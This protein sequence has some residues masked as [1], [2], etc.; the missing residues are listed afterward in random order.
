MALS[1]SAYALWAL[2]LGG[3]VVLFARQKGRKYPPGPKPLPIVGNLFDQPKLEPWKVYQEW[4]RQYD[5]DIIYFRLLSTHVIVLNSIQVAK[6]LLEKRALVYSGRPFSVM[7]HELTGWDRNLALMDYG[8]EWRSHRRMFHQQF[9]PKV[10]PEYHPASQRGISRFLNLLHESPDNFPRHIRFMTGAMILRLMYGVEAQP[11]DDRNI[12]LS[13]KAVDVLSDMANAGAYL[14]DMVP[15]LKYLP[16]WFPGAVFKRQASEWKPIVDEMFFR[17]F[18]ELKAAVDNGHPRPC[19]ASKMLARFPQDAYNE[20]I[21]TVIINTTGSAY[22]AAVD[23]TVTTLNV[24]FLLML[25]YPEAQR[26]A[27]K[28]LDTLLSQGRLPTVNDRASL[29]YTTALV[30]EVFRWHPALPLGV[31][32]KTTADDV[33]EGMYIPADTLVIANSWAILHDERRYHNPF[34]FDPA[35]YLTTS[36]NLNPDV[37]D[38]IEIFGFGRRICPGRYFALD[39]I[40]LAIANVLAAFT[41]EK[42]LDEAGNVIEPSGEFVSSLFSPPKPFKASIKPRFS[43][44][45]DLIRSPVSEFTDD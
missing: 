1:S 35:R 4:S 7:I 11:S 30:R 19:I 20:D 22:A 15:I 10:I 32:H 33:Y 42:P 18:R 5:S 17:P 45:V 31:M 8:D 14:V 44:A 6:D 21:E 37:P 28:E 12:A 43:E 29:P 25:Q 39:T 13:E 36:G 26:Q 24:F 41:I 38:P 3:A 40:W 9:T 27:Q 23:T 2:L 16:A 34:V